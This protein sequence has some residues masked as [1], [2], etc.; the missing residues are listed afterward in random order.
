[1]RRCVL[2]FMILMWMIGSA[3]LL[4][5]QTR[6]ECQECHSD[7]ELTTETESGEEI[8]LF[9]ADSL[10]D[11][12]VHADLECIDC[13]ADVTELPHDERLKKVDCGSCH[14]DAA[15]AVAQSVHGIELQARSPDSPTCADCHGTHDILSVT[16]PLSRVSKANQPKTCGRCHSDPDIIAR[17]KIPM[18]APVAIYRGSIHGQ[19]TQ[20]REDAATCSDC[21]RGHL[22][23]T[24]L[25]PNSS[26]FKLAIPKTCGKCHESIYEE[27]EISVHAEALRQGAKDAPVCTDCHGEHDILRPENPAAPTSGFRVAIEVCSPCH[28]SERLARKY[29]L[30]PARVKTYEDSYHGLALRAGKAT[31]ANCGSC[32]G[33]HGILPSSDPRSPIHPDNL[34]ET[35]GKCHPNPTMNFARGRVHLVGED[36]EARII[37]IVRKIYIVLIITIL[38]LMVTHNVIDFVAKAKRIR[39]A[40]Y[41]NR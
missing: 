24:P 2:M 21:H 11:A 15:E 1:M 23:L 14:E 38:G 8:S 41:G 6:D 36:T 34:V 16:D 3:R 39:L 29:G 33:V 30:T 31:V 17:N 35:C 25:N 22:I 20:E 13:H 26:I 19:L 5:A 37:R 7:P 32:H 40:K 10:F 18:V 4:Q 12:S 9:V 28:A 27:Y